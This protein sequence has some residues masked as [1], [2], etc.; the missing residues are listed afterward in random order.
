[1]PPVAVPSPAFALNH[2][3]APSLP[4]SAFFAL[5]RSLD[6]D[7]VEIRND[8]AGNALLDG[9]SPE[10]IAAA[11]EAAGVNIL[12]INALQRFDRWTDERAAEAR[13]LVEIARRCG[14][15]ALV[16]VPTNDGAG[17]TDLRQALAALQPILAPAGIL[18]LVEPLGFATCSLRSKAEAVAA[19]R[20]LG[21]ESVFQLV[22][23][24]FHHH[25]AGEA[26]VF[27]DMT[28]LVHISGVSDP[29]LADDALRD[30]HRVLVD[31]EDRID[32]LGQIRRLR[33]AGYQGP[34]S[35]E[36]FAPEI[37]ALADPAAA[38]SASIVHIRSRL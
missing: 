30:R 9:T 28:G 36:P 1:M 4:P 19:I 20:A 18:G 13:A 38:L 37:Q 23:D 3:C 16:L 34:L 25:L 24:T 15:R 8:L 2:I 10:A 35:F 22:H 31:A 17:E 12:S 6:I 5:A 33:A 26:E 29:S 21:G 11:A 14:A 27:A 7:R 32:N